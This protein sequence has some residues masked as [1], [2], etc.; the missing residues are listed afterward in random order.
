MVTRGTVDENIHGIQKRKTVLDAQLLN[1]RGRAAAS[2]VE[3]V[4]QGGRPS[5]KQD[6]PDFNTISSIILAQLAAQQAADSAE[7]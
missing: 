1:G 7:T 3:E 6:E 5:G 4:G 2:E